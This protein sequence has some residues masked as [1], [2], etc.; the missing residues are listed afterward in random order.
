M[1][2]FSA[3]P[4]L[5]KLTDFQR[6][7]V[8]HI[9]EVFYG[10]N[11]GNRF[12]V[13]DE[14]GLG[15]T[16][17]ARGVIAKTIEHLQHD[18]SV[19]R[20]D[21]VYVCSNQ[22]LARQNLNKLNVSGGKINTIA[23]RLT[24]LAKQDPAALAIANSP[25]QKPVNLISF[26]PGTSFKEGWAT[27]KAEERALLLLLLETIPELELT[28][29]RRIMGALK[30]LKG[31][32]KT[33][34]RFR[35]WEVAPLRKELGG[36]INA[37]IASAFQAAIAKPG[38]AGS[39]S[40]LQRVDELVTLFATPYGPA[41]DSRS[42]ALIGELRST[43][44]KI[45]VELVEPD[46]I[47][48]DEFQRFRELLDQNT[49]AGELAHYLFDYG[50]STNPATSTQP[51]TNGHPI[52]K[53]LL[54]SAT[55]YKPFTYAEENEDHHSDFLKLINWLSGH[56]G[57]NTA[58]IIESALR[59][60]RTNVISGRPV[61]TADVRN[62]LLRVMSRTERPRSVIKTMSTEFSEPIANV[63]PESMLGYVALC[64]LAGLVD[65]PMNLEY[66]K[67]TP[68]FANF[69]DGY[70][71]YGLVKSTLDSE[72]NTDTAK[73][74]QVLQALT[75]TRHLNFNRIDNF[76]P[77][78]ADYG[79]A[80]LRRLAADTVEDGWWQFLWLPPTLPYLTPGGPYAKLART[81]QNT[82]TK[83]LVFSSWVATPTAIASLLS[84][85]A[86]RRMAGDDWAGKPPEERQSD[87]LGRSSRLGLR[88]TPEGKPANMTTLALFWPMPKLALARDPL[89]ARRKSGT[90]VDPTGWL[91]LSTGQPA[92]S[93]ERLVF[94]R[95]QPPEFQGM[96]TDDAINTIVSALS[97][98]KKVFENDADTAL[99]DHIRR[100]LTAKA[101][102]RG[103][104][105]DPDTQYT[106]AN[107]AANSPGNVCYRA[108]RRITFDHPDVSPAGL[109][110]AAAHLAWSM[111]TLFSRPETTLL[112]DH[113]LPDTVY[114]QAILQYCQWG[115]LQAVMDEYLYHLHVS[116]GGN[117][118]TDATLMEFA[119]MAAEVISM[120]PAS[121]TVFDPDHPGETRR[122][123]AKFALRFGG[124]KQ[125]DDDARLPLVR[126]AFNSPFW[127]FVLAT[128]SVGQEGVD[129]H[130]YCH[131]IFH[132]NTPASPVDFEQREGR[133]D[134]YD[135]HAVRRNIAA[136]HGDEILAKKGHP[137]HNAYRVAGSKGNN[138]LGSMAPHWVYPGDALIERHVAPYALSQ[139]ERRLE[140]IKRD[141]ALYRL[142]F[143]Q[144]RQEDML[145]LLE[146]RGLT[147][148][149][150]LL[151]QMRIDL[152]PP[153]SKNLKN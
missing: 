77:I 63:T 20:I 97:A 25:G 85:E 26:T 86:D 122:M 71:I 50:L 34:K 8:E 75:E 53:T 44:A 141:V 137:W 144:P 96:N 108:L 113:L 146:Q 104:K 128:T 80:K 91:G 18:D 118:L 13:A 4:I 76:E 68:F 93:V 114:W 37:Q 132:W 100:A 41:A 7:T 35:D 124:R 78:D 62:E 5:A 29:K 81:G 58:E 125:S 151:S 19:D 134:R 54:L 139:D 16:M 133:V 65:A 84:Y 22:D 28:D 152:S 46:L 153:N 52:A 11:A 56:S 149:P 121:Y 45:S 99:A 112:L 109:W 138:G 123:A 39:P 73:T 119:Q 30:L 150:Q 32:V 51:G 90:E 21:I 111:R 147:A 14:T 79:N 95:S 105:H 72:I 31:G 135:G 6:N 102:R 110:L 33:W 98:N 94:P 59:H 101:K 3:E 48:L 87:R 116:Q 127:P 36:Q 10:P 43:L 117:P 49:A 82:F 140:Q 143:G 126:Q 55:P 64:K 40:L 103:D 23:T 66:W 120:R 145:K 2:A 69:M 15:K 57:R 9:I 47:I 60:Y 67:S 142:T 12:L 24:L 70:K 42:W 148:D 88:R 17:V 107:L 74:T 130:W 83:K 61:N 129:F 131:S 89:I 38:K 92:A 106:V 27:G 136:K 1:S 115:N